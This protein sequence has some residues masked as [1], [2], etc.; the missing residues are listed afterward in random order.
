MDNLTSLIGFVFVTCEVIYSK[1]IEDPMSPQRFGL[2]QVQ[3]T[4]GLFKDRFDLNLNYVMSLRDDNLLQ[5][6]YLEAGIKRDFHGAFRATSH[7]D[8]GAGDDRHWGW[9]SPTCELRGHFLGHWLS[10]AALIY[11]ST[12]SLEVKLKADRI[13]SELKRCQDKNGKGWIGSSPEK[14]LEWT[15]Q[16]N[17]TWAPQYVH[18]KTFMGLYDM[19][20]LV[21]NKEA[22]E[23]SDKFADWFICW[24]DPFS[25]EEMDNILDVETG[26]MLEVWANLYGATSDP[27][28]LTLLERYTRSR[29]FDPLLNGQDVLTNRHANTTIPE[30]HGAA[31]AYE[32]T[33]DERWRQIVEAYWRSAVTDRGMFCTG[34]QTNGEVWTPPHEFMARLGDKNQEHC[35]VYN[36]IRLADYLFRWTGDLAY[37]DYIERNIYNGVLAQQNRTTGMIAYFLP[38]ESGGKKL[39][40]SPTYDFWCCHGTLVQAHSSHNAYV[41]YEDEAGIV[42]CQYIPTILKTERNGSKLTIQQT[43]GLLSR[44]SASNNS[45]TAGDRHRPERWKVTLK[46]DCETPTEFTLKLRLP[47]WLSGK[48]E[49][50]I[51]GE[52]LAVEQGPS[53]FLSITRAWTQHTIILKLPKSITVSPLPD[54]PDICAFMDGPVVLAGLCSEERMLIGDK[55]DASSILTPDNEREWGNWLPGYR[56]R[57]QPFGLRFKPLYEITDEAYAVYFP[58]RPQSSTFPT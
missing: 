33:G 4:L 32:V 47:W 53:D 12:G 11:K 25:R 27:K 44:G 34:G 56:T 41:Y 1:H 29:F 49:V 21:G 8:P 39:W 58:I 42:V 2:D 57:N 46:I 23:I 7:G 54:S 3:L 43:T 36:M 50:S 31:R 45:G 55:E 22:L 30:V 10:A 13:V 35:T 19:Y 52:S 16:G 51:D 37:A 18:H 40:G 15:A 6:F 24:T 9:E 48:P 38:L 14:Y 26:G 5:N 20:A 17:P 28:Y